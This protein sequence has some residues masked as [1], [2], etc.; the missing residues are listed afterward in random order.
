[1]RRTLVMGLVGG[2][3]GV[4]LAQLL[5]SQGLW[6]ESTLSRLLVVVASAAVFLVVVFLSGRRVKPD[7]SIDEDR[8]PRGRPLHE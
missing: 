1:M 6:P 7:P 8:G 4:L 3:V 2:V 5:V